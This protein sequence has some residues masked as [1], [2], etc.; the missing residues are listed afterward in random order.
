MILKTHEQAMKY[1]KEI[2]V[3]RQEEVFVFPAP[4][5]SIAYKYGYRYATCVASEKASYAANGAQFIGSV[6]P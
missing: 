1:A 6:K 5:H 2:A 4:K 3:L